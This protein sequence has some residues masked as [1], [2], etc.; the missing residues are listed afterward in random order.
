MA[1]AQAAGGYPPQGGQGAPG[2]PGGPGGPGGYVSWP[3]T[4]G[5]VA[6]KLR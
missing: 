3:T 2:A 4:L 6:T 5:F 1:A